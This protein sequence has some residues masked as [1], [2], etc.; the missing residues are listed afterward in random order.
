[1]AKLRSPNY[2]K[3]NL[4][5][6]VNKVDLVYKAEHTHPADREV[7]ARDLNY[8]SLNGASL[9][10]IGALN[11]YGLLE[12]V[13]DQLKVSEDAVTILELPKGHH[14]RVAA[15][16]RRANAPKLFA[17]LQQ[18]F[19]DSL[20]SD[21]NL[22]HSLIKRKFLPKG[23]DEAIRVYRETKSFVNAEAREYSGSEKGGPE[24]QFKPFV[25][26]PMQSSVRS[27]HVGPNQ[28]SFGTGTERPV[29]PSKV[30]I[31]TEDGR[32]LVFR[33]LTELAFKLSRGSEAKI[34]IYGDA[35]QEA[36]DKLVQHLNLSKDTFPTQEEIAAQGGYRAAIWKNKDH[37]QPVTV[38][39][40]LGVGADGRRYLKIAESQV[41]IPEDEIDFQDRAQGVA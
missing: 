22:R 36:I 34:T 11:S 14:E 29:D 4:E 12:A 20:P 38:T 33:Q 1:M 7:V 16:L 3:I 6:A 17:E 30:R 21:V 40:D 24:G 39:G 8:T 13:G 35:S 27:P 15:L 18:E 28:T 5:T 2:P 41:G 37:D 23:A 26:T 25:E 32:P 9:T 31:A 10:T 19:G